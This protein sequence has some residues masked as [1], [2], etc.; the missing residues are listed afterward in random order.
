MKE[1]T[2][3]PLATPLETGGDDLLEFLRILAHRMSQP[4]TSLRG[5]VEVA[6]LGDLDE[7]ECR[8]VLKISLQESQRMAEILQAL[9]DVLDMEG[10]AEQVQPLS[11]TQNVEKLL[12]EAAS[13]DKEGCPRFVSEVKDEVWVRA[14]PR[15]LHTATARLI[16]GAIRAARA[17]REV[18]VSLSV[19]EETACLS[20]WE[21]AAPLAAG[22]FSP[23]YIQES[24]IL[25]GLGQWVVRRAIEHQGGWLKVSPVSEGCRCYELSLPLVTSDILQR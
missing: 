8:R 7:S 18:R 14:S 19:R 11:W 6:L 1:R 4:L 3:P 5:T 23:A 12:E 15:H 20:V 2:R 13:G 22:R 16:G 25:E 17:R 10:A 9:R 21:G 24:P